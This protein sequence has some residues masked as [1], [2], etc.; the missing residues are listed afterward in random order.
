MVTDGHLWVSIIDVKGSVFHLLPNINRQDT[1]VSVLRDGRDGEVPVRVAYAVDEAQ[2]TGRLAFL[3]DGTTL[4]KNKVL[5]VHGD[6]PLFDD[7]RPTS[8]SADSF[9]EALSEAIAARAEAGQIT[10]DSR[11]LVSA[12][13]N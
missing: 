9:A 7:L 10:A 12:E 4:G 2:G 8:E 6:A 1:A 3:V 5:V 11:I 13:Q